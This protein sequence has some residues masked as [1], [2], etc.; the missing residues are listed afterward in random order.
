MKKERFDCGKWNVKKENGE[1]LIAGDRYIARVCDW[2]GYNPPDSKENAILHDEA[3]ANAMLMAA[4]PEMLAA[5]QSIQNHALCYN[6]KSTK[7]LHDPNT[8]RVLAIL[9]SA[10]SAIGKAIGE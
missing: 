8:A 5:L 6:Y 7:K 4:A 1:I 2:A 9:S 3:E 10:S